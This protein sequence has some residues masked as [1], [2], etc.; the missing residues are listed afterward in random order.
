MCQD[1][2]NKVNLKN[3]QNL[4]DIWVAQLG[5]KCFVVPLLLVTL[6][7]VFFL[8]Q[9]TT[10][11]IFIIWITII[12]FSLEDICVPPSMFCLP[13]E[14]SRSFQHKALAPIETIIRHHVALRLAGPVH[15][16]RA[17][18]TLGTAALAQFFITVSG[19]L[20]SP[21]RDEGIGEVRMEGPG[22]RWCRSGGQLIVVLIRFGGVYFRG[23]RDS[24]AVR[25]VVGVLVGHRPSGG[26]ATLKL[27]FGRS[28]RDE[29]IT[30]GSGVI[31][32]SEVCCIGRGMRRERGHCS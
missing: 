10:P 8:F 4:G 21:S 31:V 13:A 1:N 14:D 3:Y 16:H 20:F 18:L 17:H 22:W 6:K 2:G 23:R 32:Y 25:R 7:D 5:L 11:D 26:F 9:W 27:M 12:D 24:F 30:R 15:E 19:W 29:H 28:R